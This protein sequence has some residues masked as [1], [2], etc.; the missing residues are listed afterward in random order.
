M[1]FVK[2]FKKCQSLLIALLQ[3]AIGNP[4]LQFLA[5]PNES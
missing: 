2:N 4:S 1:K 3:E 5:I